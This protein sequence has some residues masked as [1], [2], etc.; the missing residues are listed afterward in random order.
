MTDKGL[1]LIIQIPCLNEE[2]TLPV[3]LRD[4]PRTIPGISRIERLI[5]N[6]GSTDSTIEVARAHGVEH[7][8]SFPKRKGLARAFE[9]GVEEA[10]GLGADIVVNTD[11]DNQYKGEDIITLVR[12]IVEGRA[13]IVIGN[14]DIDNIGHFSFIKKKLQ[15]A[16]SWVIRQVSGTDIPDA[17]TGFR[18][19]S[20]KALLEMNIVS[21]FSYTLETIISA[22]KKD[23]A[24]ANVSIRVNKPLRTSRLYTNVFHYIFKSASTILRIYTMYEA[25]R[26]FMLIGTLIFSGGVVLCLRYLYYRIFEL[27][28]SGHI[29]SLILAAVLLIVGFQIMVFSLL[30]DLISSNRKL[31]EDALTKIKKIHWGR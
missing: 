18:A 26:V 23:L 5:I 11:G 17:T 8:I 31:I 20:R 14:R 10:L 1:F 28:P 19:Y 21:K 16:G 27:N 7:I 2:T 15:R 25:L 22:G 13:D 4:I 3:T 24:I 30:A 9:A 12:P 6:D 29:Q